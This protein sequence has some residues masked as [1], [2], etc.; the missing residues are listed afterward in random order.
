[1]EKISQIKKI[2]QKVLLKN[3]SYYNNMN[4]ENKNSSYIMYTFTT[5]DKL[6]VDAT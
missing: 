6:L 4:L 1:M 2:N 5:T 3:K